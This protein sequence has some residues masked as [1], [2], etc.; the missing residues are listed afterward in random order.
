MNPDGRRSTNPAGVVTLHFGIYVPPVAWSYEEMLRRARH[1][2]D[3]GFE[4]FWM[5][6]HVASA[7]THDAPVL[8]PWTIATALLANTTRLRVGHMVL[9]ATFR[10]PA[11]L[12]KMATALDIVSDGRFNF[13]I[14]SGSSEPEHVRLGIPWRNLAYRSELLEETLEIVTRMFTGEPT[15]YEGKHFQVTELANVPPP[16]QQPRPPVYVGGI[17]EKRT[18]PLVAR[19][20]DV[21]NVPFRALGE[22]APKSEALDAECVA[23]GR[24]PQSIRR[25]LE[26]VM[27]IAPDDASLA[28]ARAKG[29]RRY[30]GTRWGLDEGGY[31]GT[32]N[33]IVDRIGEHVEMGFEEFV[34]YPY[35]QD[36]PAAIELLASEV[37][38]QLR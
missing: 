24:E 1:V 33:A 22:L 26:A 13:G 32:P 17:G 18:L 15:T 25:S 14:G 9:C 35:D 28:E 21:W 7:M 27:I 30:P 11:L 29:E 19:F 6:D 37:L 5:F 2:E 16:V 36:D 31:V 4:S 34:F 12:G 10:H 3:L 23:I 38:S 8:E 20:A